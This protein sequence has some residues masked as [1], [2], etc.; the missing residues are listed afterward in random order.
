MPRPCP[1]DRAAESGDL[2]HEQI[3]FPVSKVERDAAGIQ[4]FGRGAWALRYNNDMGGVR[5]APHPTLGFP[6]YFVQPVV[7]EVRTLAAAVSTRS[8][9]GAV[10]EVVIRVAL[11]FMLVLPVI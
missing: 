8:K 2:P 4:A 10:F 1:R 3:A 5:G 7:A 9:H 11:L 6:A